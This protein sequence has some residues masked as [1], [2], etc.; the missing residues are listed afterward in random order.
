MLVYSV[1]VNMKIGGVVDNVR[2]EDMWFVDDWFV[3]VNW[4]ESC[5]LVWG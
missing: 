1:S 4:V 5:V 3:F 2:C